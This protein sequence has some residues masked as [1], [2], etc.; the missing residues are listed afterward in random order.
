MRKQLTWMG[1]SAA[2][3]TCLAATLLSGVAHADPASQ[4][5]MPDPDAYCVNNAPYGAQVAE[6][7][8]N[9][10][11]TGLVGDAG[12]NDWQCQYQV[13]ATIPLANA[14]GEDAE[15]PLP[16]QTETFGVDWAGM[17][18]QQYSGSTLEW[19]VTPGP[20]VSGQ[21][22]FGA[23]WLCVG[24]PGAVYD[25]TETPTGPVGRVA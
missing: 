6:A 12:A 14:D 9:V 8:W 2:A 23:P 10:Q 16:P 4:T 13:I 20:V 17:C 15:I 25:Q 19:A 22:P 24:A 7:G 11:F 18:S 21:G 5:L 1:G 3:A